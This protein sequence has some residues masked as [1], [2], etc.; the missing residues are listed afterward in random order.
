MRR[1]T[2]RK[3]S[4]HGKGVFALHALKAGERIIEYKGKKTSWA[5]AIRR[6]A[7]HGAPGHTFYF[8]LED[9]DVI[10]GGRGGNSSRWFNHACSANCEAVEVAGRVYI[11]AS[12]NIAAGEKLFLTYGL[13]VDEP[14]TLGI[15]VL[16]ACSY[17]H[18]RCSG[19]MLDQNIES[20][21]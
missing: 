12:R 13:S 7:K 21:S 11:E 10:D 8:A 5:A 2:V 1:I 17:G 9:G 16:Y 14:V 18:V 20:G 4:V 19:T 3:S 6:Y 15:Q